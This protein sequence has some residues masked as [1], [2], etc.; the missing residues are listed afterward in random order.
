MPVVLSI[1]QTIFD[2]SEVKGVFCLRR[3]ILLC[4][5]FL[6]SYRIS[7]THHSFNQLIQIAHQ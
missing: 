6:Y 2:N 4:E 5:E 1:H 7:C 3:N